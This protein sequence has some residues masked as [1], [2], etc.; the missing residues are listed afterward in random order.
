MSLSNMLVV[1]LGSWILSSVWV[2]GMNKHEPAL[3]EIETALRKEENPSE[4]VQWAIER[5]N[6]LQK[7]LEDN[8]R[9]SQWGDGNPRLQVQNPDG[10]LRQSKQDGE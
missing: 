4:D 10:T 6:R 1:W 9:Q 5:I 3:T 7:E 2:A 8:A